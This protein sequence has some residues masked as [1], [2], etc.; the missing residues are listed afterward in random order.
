MYTFCGRRP[1]FAR[2]LARS[3]LGFFVARHQGIPRFLL[4]F[5]R[6]TKLFPLLLA[7]AIALLSG[8][9]A[10]ADA[11]VAVDDNY[12]VDEGGTLT[13][14]ASFPDTM[15][16]LDPSL[17][18][19]FNDVTNYAVATTEDRTDSLSSSGAHTFSTAWGKTE[20]PTL[21]TSNNFKGFADTNTWF[22]FGDQ[23]GGSG[24]IGT[25]I[26]PTSGWGSD[27]GALSFWF[28][29][30]DSGGDS[31]NASTAQQAPR[32]FFSGISAKGHSNPP[33]SMFSTAVLVGMIDSKI[34]FRVSD[35]DVPIVEFIT[36]NTYDDSEWHHVVASWD[37]SGNE[38]G[39]Y[40]D[41]GSLGGATKSETMK[42]FDFDLATDFDFERDSGTNTSPTIGKGG[43]GGTAYTGYMDEFAIWE[44][45][46]LTAQDASDL[47]HSGHG[48]LL[49]N[50]ENPEEGSLT[51]TKL[52]NPSAGALTLQTNGGFNYDATGV[53]DG[54]YSF[55]YKVNDG[56]A[57]S[58]VATVTIQVG[59]QPQFGPSSL[60]KI[61][62]VLFRLRNASS[63]S[64]LSAPLSTNSVICSVA[65]ITASVAIASSS[66]AVV[67]DSAALTSSTTASVYPSTAT[68]LVS[69]AS[70]TAS[71]ALSSF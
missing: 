28:K 39:F 10:R 51:A 52:S 49:A 24:Y 54:E 55:T 60:K 3:R 40:V 5:F 35:S 26:S 15:A 63:I 69:V 61:R 16:A 44:H 38:S 8:T 64:P 31:S 53:P 56:V 30:E 25:L 11:P 67:T 1:N 70:A 62:L 2:A 65:S 12:V 9:R 20:T 7:L 42:S 71:I 4:S 14:R 19:R 34:I 59:E 57:D 32:V 13:V 66:T 36:T 29:T 21:R 27:E 18:W 43:Y 23:A 68:A 45:K 17:Y 6:I 47:Y 50:D 22:G 41:G 37:N 58:N 46:T 33:A 48:G